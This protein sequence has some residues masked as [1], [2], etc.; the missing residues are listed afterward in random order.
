MAVLL[1]AISI[2][3]Q[4]SF[5]GVSRSHTTVID[6]TAVLDD[7]TVENV[8]MGRDGSHL[9]VSMDLILSEMSTR[10]RRA[11]LLTPCL[12]NGTDTLDL[13]SVGVYGRQRYYFNLR[14]EI[15]VSGGGYRNQL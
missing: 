4:E 5:S 2:N 9:S 1:S 6:G 15:S 7:V 10:S 14:N 12:A 8:S 13:P 11:V 3:A